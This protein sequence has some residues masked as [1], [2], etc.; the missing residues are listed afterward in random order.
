MARK[1][2][3]SPST[4]TSTSGG[5]RKKA[6]TSRRRATV[7]KKKEKKV[8][9]LSQGVTEPSL[10]RLARR[11]GLERVPKPSRDL[12]KDESD[13]YLYQLL[14]TSI[15]CAVSMKRRTLILDDVKFA[16]RTEFGRELY[17]FRPKQRRT[18]AKKN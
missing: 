4:S 17:G 13:Y 2:N 6:V 3:P 5:K 11:G 9:A 10:A 18:E 12:L 7:D 16:S 14:R 8:K 15:L 1:K